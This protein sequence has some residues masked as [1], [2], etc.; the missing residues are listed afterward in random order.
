M[1]KRFTEGN[2]KMEARNKTSEEY[3]QIAKFYPPERNRD[4]VLKGEYLNGR[5]FILAMYFFFNK[6]FR[7]CANALPKGFT[8]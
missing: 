8:V 5:C 6:Q 7:T 1:R 4:A 3:L 2:I